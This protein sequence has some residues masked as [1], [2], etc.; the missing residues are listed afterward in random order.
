MNTTANISATT[1]FFAE[2]AQVFKSIG[3]TAWSGID[4]ATFPLAER[5]MPQYQ[6]LG[7]SK[8]AFGLL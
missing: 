8:I 5:N 1:G 6:I 2:S 4:R 3:N 7:F